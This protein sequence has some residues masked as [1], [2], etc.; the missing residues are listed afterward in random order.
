MNHYWNLDEQAKV[1]ECPWCNANS[2]APCITNKDK[3][4]KQGF[5]H[6]VRSKYYIDTLKDMIIMMEASNSGNRQPLT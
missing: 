2:L 3:P 5:V 6:R 4:H 1:V